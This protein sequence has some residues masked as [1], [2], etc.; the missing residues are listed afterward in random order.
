M[1]NLLFVINTLS[2]AGAE[3][4]LLELLRHLD[5][6]EYEVSLYVLTGQGELLQDLPKHVKLLN[7]HYSE[8]SVLSRE[9]KEKLRKTVLRALFTKGTL[10]RLLPYM[11]RNLF[12]MLSRKQILPDKLLWRGLSDG[13]EHFDTHYDLAVAFIEGGSAYY[14]AD[15]VNADK[16]AAF[17]H[18]DYKRAGYTRALDKDCY[19]KFDKVFAVSDEVKSTFLEFYPE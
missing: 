14:V 12:I 5:E 16:K 17:F 13:G 6:E 1:K 18:T 15:H 7:R 4:A 8:T 2:Q 10:F 11:L 9:G 3:T 19:L